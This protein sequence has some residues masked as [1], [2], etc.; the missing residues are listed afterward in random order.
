MI[1]FGDDSGGSISFLWTKLCSLVNS[2]SSYSQHNYYYCWLWVFP[3]FWTVQKCATVNQNNPSRM[4]TNNLCTHS[5]L[6]WREGWGWV[7]GYERRLWL[8]REN[9]SR[10]KVVNV[11]LPNLFIIFEWMALY[12]I[13]STPFF[14]AFLIF[15]RL[16]VRSFVHSFFSISF[17]FS[18]SF[19]FF[20]LKKRNWLYLYNTH[21]KKRKKRRSTRS[22]SGGAYEWIKEWNCELC[23]SVIQHISFEENIRIW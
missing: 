13:L 5:S 1:G 22:A 14:L 23:A 9:I 10:R 12:V 19:Y 17:L 6:Q 15:F 21:R 16:F 18:Y 4:N 20:I 8:R 2:L 3:R 11:F 7:S